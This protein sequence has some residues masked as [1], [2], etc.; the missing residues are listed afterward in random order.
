METVQWK[1]RQAI[2]KREWNLNLGCLGFSKQQ[3]KDPSKIFFLNQMSLVIL[4]EEIQPHTSC[5]QL[6]NEAHI[7]VG[8]ISND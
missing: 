3:H 2:Q 1:K 8:N 5:N 7:L 6:C 4:K